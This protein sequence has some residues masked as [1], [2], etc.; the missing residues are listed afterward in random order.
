MDFWFQHD[1]IC[2][3][4]GEIREGTVNKKKRKNKGIRIA[5]AVFVILAA[6]AGIVWL[7]I[8]SG[9]IPAF[10]SFSGNNAGKENAVSSSI[11]TETAK[12]GS[13]RVT[14]Q[15]SG[16]VEPVSSHAVTLEYDG[17]LEEIS[18]EPGDMVSKGDILAVYDIESIDDAVDAKKRSLILRMRQ[19]LRCRGAE[20]TRSNP[21]RQGASNA[22]LP[23][24]GMLLPAS[25]RKR[26]DFW[27]CRRTDV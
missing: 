1:C 4:K 16:A 20:R 24:R 6:A 13:I 27:S 10:G 8:R 2:R 22:Y 12:R 21:P 25:Q 15:G 7:L 11:Q 3:T 9:K 19:S 14:A 5:L 18:I 26:A 23:T 17:V